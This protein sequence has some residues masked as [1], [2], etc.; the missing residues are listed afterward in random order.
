MKRVDRLGQTR[1]VGRLA[2]P[3]GGPGGRP[4]E[5]SGRLST[6]S[7]GRAPSATSPTWTR[8]LYSHSPTMSPPTPPS[9]SRFSSRDVMRSRPLGPLLSGL[10]HAR[11]PIAEHI[12]AALWSSLDRP[13]NEGRDLYWD[14]LLHSLGD[15]LRRKLLVRI[16]NYRPQSEW[17][18]RFFREGEATGRVQALRNVL[19]DLL[20]Q[21]GVT[22]QSQHEARIDGCDD[23]KRLRGWIKRAATAETA[24]DVFGRV[25]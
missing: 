23:P 17:G 12:G 13:E 7:R 5:C 16:S 3:V 15:A 22:P 19:R 20:D 6:S 14:V 25:K 11:E 10:A 9:S 2:W 8:I 24:A 18:K 1:L 21:G 4:T